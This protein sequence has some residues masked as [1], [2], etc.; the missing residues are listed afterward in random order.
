M[1]AMMIRSDHHPRPML[2][3]R[4]KR[5]SITGVQRISRGNQSRPATPPST[6]AMEV[7]QP[8]ARFM[9]KSHET[10]GRSSPHS[11]PM[12]ASAPVMIA[13]MESF[14]FMRHSNRIR[15]SRRAVIM[16]EIRL[17]TMRRRPPRKT[18]PITM[19]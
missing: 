2:R 9:L 3:K 14:R 6:R 5:W 13:A 1:S 15:G 7:A 11:S 4:R 17:P 12:M 10:E 18:V 8:N 19:G 16:S